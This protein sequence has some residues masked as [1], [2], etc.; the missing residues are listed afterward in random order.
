MPH[1][2]AR[3]EL[4]DQ[5]LAR[6]REQRLP[7]ED[8]GET[9]ARLLVGILD[10]DRSGTGPAPA[11]PAD[12]AVTEDEEEPQAVPAPAPRRLPTPDQLFEVAVLIGGEWSTLAW[13]VLSSDASLVAEAM[14]ARRSFLELAQVWRDG[15]IVSEHRKLPPAG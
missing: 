2:F 14:L 10:Q 3:I 4:D 11:E 13:T 8:L 15:E 7:T 1:L 5:Q 12:A 6:L 9:S